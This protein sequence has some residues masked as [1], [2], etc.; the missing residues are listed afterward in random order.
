MDLKQRAS[1]CV[2]SP[3][4]N[5]LIQYFDNAGVGGNVG[6]T[7]ETLVQNLNSDYK[8]SYNNLLSVDSF[9]CVNTHTDKIKKQYDFHKEYLEALFWSNY[10]RLMNGEDIPTPKRVSLKDYGTMS[11]NQSK[12]VRKCVEN[13]IAMT[14][15]GYDN[16]VSRKSQSYNTFVTLTLPSKQIHSD[17]I[18]RK[19]LTKFLDNLKKSYKV[20]HYIWRAES[21]AN[22]NIHFHLVLD[23]FIDYKKVRSLWNSQIQ[24]L[25]YIKAYSEMKLNKG[26][27]YVPYY[28]RNKQKIK[29]P[30][31]K[32]EQFDI[33][34]KDKKEGFVD[35]N[36]TDIHK[37]ENVTNSVNYILKYLTKLEADKR[38]INGALWGAA[39]L[40]K[41]LT[42]PRFYEGEHEFQEL[43]RLSKSTLVKNVFKDDFCSI[44]VGRVYGVLQ[45][46]YKK[47]WVSVV[48]HYR[49]LKK[50]SKKSFDKLAL[51]FN[52]Y[53]DSLKNKVVALSLEQIAAKNVI[54]M[55]KAAEL[56]RTTYLNKIALQRFKSLYLKKG[57]LNYIDYTQLNLNI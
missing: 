1:I 7:K 14:L 27:V 56:K 39:N 15:I 38:P 17:K 25:G 49:D 44:Y 22:G 53:K 26:F 10:L 12:N 8:E 13:L 34:L 47:T 30:K 20:V 16:K 23:R 28:I 29:H 9:E 41:K 18:I 45:S 40:T 3:R 43:N 54:E 46:H 51:D 2:L 35:P 50:M 48:R 36:T 21:Q 11:K 5:S 52:L 32:N 6:G 33:Y 4:N 37:L 24:P 19:C 55:N 31:T 42:Y 57:Y